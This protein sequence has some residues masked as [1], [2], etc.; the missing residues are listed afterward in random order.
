MTVGTD[1]HRMTGQAIAYPAAKLD[2]GVLFAGER[3][4]DE[5]ARWVS[6]AEQEGTVGGRTLGCH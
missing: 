6:V 2:C 1:L 3:S 5:R 4:I